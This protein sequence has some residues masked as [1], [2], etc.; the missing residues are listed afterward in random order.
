VARKNLPPGHSLNAR[1]EN[2]FIH[3]P[4]QARDLNAVDGNAR[5]PKPLLDVDEAYRQALSRGLASAMTALS[6]ERA[7]HPQALT[8]LV[9]KLR[10]Q[11]IAKTHRTIKLAE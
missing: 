6:R 5:S 1:V 9:L 3:I 2:P 10:E 4:F 11:G 7:L 8:H